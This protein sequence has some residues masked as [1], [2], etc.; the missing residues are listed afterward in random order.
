MPPLLSRI[1]HVAFH[2]L[3]SWKFFSCIAIDQIIFEGNK[4]T[5]IFINNLW[6]FDNLNIHKDDIV[7]IFLS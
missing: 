1:K 3:Q 2:V 5:E 4:Y 7:Q 6:E